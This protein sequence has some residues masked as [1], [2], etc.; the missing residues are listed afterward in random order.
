MQTSV[1]RSVLA[2][3]LGVVSVLAWECQAGTP[4]TAETY[5][6]EMKSLKVRW[7]AARKN[8]RR[9]L[10]EER[11]AAQ[12][13]V[14]E[15]KRA[16][17]DAMEAHQEHAAAET[18]ADEEPGSDGVGA[19]GAAG[20]GKGG[21]AG[22]A[23]GGASAGAAAGA[24]GG[25]DPRLALCQMLLERHVG[26]A[27]AKPEG[28]VDDVLAKV[29]QPYKDKLRAKVEEDL[30]SLFT[31]KLAG[32]AA[33]LPKDAVADILKDL[34]EIKDKLKPESFQSALLKALD[35]Q[36]VKEKIKAIPK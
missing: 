14:D 6:T 33:P 16:Y 5:A 34:Q 26:C 9:M 27:T 4:T 25:V 24:M 11:Q 31:D 21:V 18:T 8:H 17:E 1:Q 23:I 12:K 3:V 22:G 19:G 36:S 29:L 32:G 7:E 30:K 28:F 15:A 20:A 10:D 13:K 35:D 2:M